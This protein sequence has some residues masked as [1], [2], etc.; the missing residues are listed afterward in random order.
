[1]QINLKALNR[2]QTL[3]E[4]I[5]EKNEIIKQLQEKINELEKKVNKK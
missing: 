1:M 5:Y 4:M 2:E 3:I